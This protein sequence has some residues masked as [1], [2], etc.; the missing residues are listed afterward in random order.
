MYY[1]K[2]KLVLSRNKYKIDCWVSGASGS[3]PL[4]FF[5]SFITLQVGKLFCL[6]YCT[7][8]GQI[9]LFHLLHCKR[10]NFFVSFIRLQ[11]GKHF[12]FH[13]LDCKWA[14]SLLVN[15]LFI[16]LEVG[17]GNFVLFCLIYYT[18]SG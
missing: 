12:L 2:K 15:L 13:L 6:I 10:A 16:I 11:V 3:L 17:I 9:F 14:T 18:A 1:Q 7:A 5:V 4:L 8:S